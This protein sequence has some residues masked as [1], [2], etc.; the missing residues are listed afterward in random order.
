M[1]CLGVMLPLLIV[2]PTLSLVQVVDAEQSHERAHVAQAIRVQPS[3][4][5]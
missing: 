2:A 5:A 4:H 1:G 3:P